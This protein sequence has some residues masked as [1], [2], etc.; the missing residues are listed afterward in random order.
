M[1]YNTQVVHAACRGLDLG[2]D[3]IVALAT[4]S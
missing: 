3:A 4:V 2:D 1:H